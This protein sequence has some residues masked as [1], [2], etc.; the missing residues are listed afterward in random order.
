MTYLSVLNSIFIH[1]ADFNV[2]INIQWM[3]MLYFPLTGLMPMCLRV[4][5]HKMKAVS[6]ISSI[7]SSLNT[8]NPLLVDISFSV[9]CSRTFAPMVFYICS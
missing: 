5:V 4:K 7:C 1:C 6:Y 8:L 2:I 3:E 9:G